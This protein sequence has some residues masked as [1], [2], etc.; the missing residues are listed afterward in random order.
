[1]SETTSE[2]QATE[3]GPTAYACKGTNRIRRY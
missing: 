3:T 2:I 1:M